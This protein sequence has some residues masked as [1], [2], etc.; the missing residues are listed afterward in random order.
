[1]TTCHPGG[2]PVQSAAIEKYRFMAMERLGSDLQRVCD[3]NRGQLKRTTV[4]QIALRLLDVLEYIHENEYVHAD[5]KAANLMLG[6]RDPEKVYLADYGLSY[7]Y[8]PGGIHKEYVEAP[9]KG[10]NG[11]VEY[12]SLDAHRGVAPSR[13][14]DLQV[15]GFCMLH[16]LCGTLPWAG[17]LR[18]PAQVQEAKA[19]LMDNLPGSVQ[20]LSTGGEATD[21]VARLLLYVKSL[22]YQDCPDY[23]RLRALLG[24]GGQGRLDFSR[25]PGGYAAA[26]LEP[27]G[28]LPRG[29]TGTGDEEEEGAKGREVTKTKPSGVRRGAAANRPRTEQKGRTARGTSKLGATEL[30]GEEEEEEAAAARKTKPIP[31]QYIWGPPV[32]KPE[33]SGAASVRRLRPRARAEPLDD[34]DYE[35]EDEEDWEEVVRQIDACHLRGPPIRGPRPAQSRV[36]RPKR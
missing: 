19:Q 21:E 9:K 3:R 20:Q 22:G 31:S 36:V 30:K 8:R 15:L 33:A 35:S 13:R 11:T 5:I 26:A 24:R 32:N 2:E 27:E 4:L 29:K 1:M 6:Y 25:S 17:V 34:E 16:W 10:H 18:N 7:R 28:P 12:T 23:Q 14:G